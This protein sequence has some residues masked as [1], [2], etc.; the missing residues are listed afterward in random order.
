MQT[1][2][3]GAYEKQVLKELLQYNLSKKKVAELY[4][5]YSIDE[6]Q[7]M[8]VVLKDQDANLVRRVEK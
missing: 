7:Q 2:G 3:L 1:N 4:R 6:L 5:K 8:L